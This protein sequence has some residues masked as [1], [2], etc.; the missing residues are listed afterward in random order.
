[1][2]RLLA[3][4]CLLALTAFP[5]P[6]AQAQQQLPTLGVCIYNYEDTFITS[7]L[8]VIRREAEQVATLI[9]Y[10]G[11]NNQNLQNDQVEELLKSGVDALIVNPVDR[12]AAIYLIQMAMRYQKPIVFINRE[13]LRE[14]LA[15]YHLAY[16]V[17]IDPKEQGLLSGKLAAHYFRTHPKADRNGDGVM[18]L[19]LLKGEPG[20]Q[21]AELRTQYAMKALQ[22][23]GLHTEKLD[24][25][26]A[27]W[28]RS[29]GQEKMASFLNTFGERIECVIS[30]NDD[31]ALGAIDALKAAGYFSGDKY[32]PV[33]GI[34]ATAPAREALAQGS[35]Y[36]TVFNDALGQGNAAVALAILLA[37]GEAVVPETFP[38]DIQDKVVYIQSTSMISDRVP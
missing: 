36:A 12:T 10:D 6:A 5:C 17:G 7:L 15:L 34:D 19:V 1:M 35:L 8:E 13:P 28:E 14:D 18:Q 20:H 3:I 30:N 4:W 2:K 22:Q 32:M 27:L 9:T 33:I 24:E 25:A 16:Y 11:H 21:D 37:R 31:M 26:A 23:E 38:Y 29:L